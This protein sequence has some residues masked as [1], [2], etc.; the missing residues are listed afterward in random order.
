MHFEIWLSHPHR[1]SRGTQGNLDYRAPA[2]VKLADTVMVPLIAQ[3]TPFDSDGVDRACS[4]V[5]IYGCK[6][7]VSIVSCS[8]GNVLKGKDVQLGVAERSLRE[9]MRQTSTV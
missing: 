2:A 7:D 6:E 9:L 3:E 5:V 1:T 4:R 8:L